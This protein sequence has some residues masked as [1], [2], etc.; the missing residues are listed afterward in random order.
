[1]QLPLISDL[2]ASIISFNFDGRCLFRLL[3]RT[4]YRPEEKKLN[5]WNSTCEKNSATKFSFEDCGQDFELLHP[6][7]TVPHFQH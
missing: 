5:S 1:M 2:V 3:M 4:D 6:P 7:I